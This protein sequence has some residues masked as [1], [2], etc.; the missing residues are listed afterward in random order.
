[1]TQPVM[2]FVV[3]WAEARDPDKLDGWSPTEILNMD[4]EN[5][6]YVEPAY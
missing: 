2:N 5:G 3:R 6:V 1:M 4:H